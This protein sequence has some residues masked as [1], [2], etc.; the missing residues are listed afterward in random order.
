MTDDYTKILNDASNGNSV[1]AAELLEQ[2]YRE[3]KLMARRKVAHEAGDVQATLLVHE[4]YLRLFGGKAC[5]WKSRAHFFG[6]AAE[7]MR[8]VLVDLARERNA[9]KRGGNRLKVTLSDTVIKGNATSSP[10]EFLD[11]NEAIDRLAKDDST[12]AEIIKL[13][14]FAGQ[15]MESIAELLDTSLSS[16]ERKWRLARA[17]LIDQMN[18]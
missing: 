9:L 4:V 10:E 14:F 17:Y 2:I 6:A 3:L 12:L 11:L 16:I 13:R 7:S 18:R 5:D 1:A 15:T 8:Q